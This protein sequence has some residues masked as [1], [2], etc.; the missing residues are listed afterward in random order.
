ME[1]A[2]IGEGAEGNQA[3]GGQGVKK[4]ASGGQLGMDLFEVGHGI[5]PTL[6]EGE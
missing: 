3:T 1:A 4:K 6:Q 5:A 2:G